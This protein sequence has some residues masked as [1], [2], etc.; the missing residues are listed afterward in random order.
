MKVV[1]HFH[2]IDWKVHEVDWNLHE[3]EFALM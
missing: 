2:N 1:K 3:I